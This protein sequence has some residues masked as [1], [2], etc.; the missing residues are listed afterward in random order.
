MLPVEAIRPKGLRFRS[1]DLINFPT[2]S[3]AGKPVKKGLTIGEDV[4]QS[5][6]NSQKCSDGV[7]RLLGSSRELAGGASQCGKQ[8]AV[9]LPSRLC[10]RLGLLAKHDWPRYRLWTCWSPRKMHF[11]IG[12]VIRVVPRFYQFAPEAKLA[13]GDFLWQRNETIKM[14]MQPPSQACPGAGGWTQM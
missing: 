14:Y 8:K 3:F 11:P 9:C 7:M 10:E 13:S 1:Y 12:N 6:T 4:I 5:I 2:F